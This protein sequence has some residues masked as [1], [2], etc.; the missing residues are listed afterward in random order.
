MI[1]KIFLIFLIGFVNGIAIRQYSDDGC[2]ILS[3]TEY[4]KQNGCYTFVSTGSYL[5]KACNCTMI[6]YNIYNGGNCLG[7]LIGTIITQENFCLG[8]RQKISCNEEPS[9]S[10]NLLNNF[11]LFFLPFF[12]III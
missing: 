8:T 2:N 6:E 7:N 5:F 12:L 11:Y 9:L 1:P 3:R 4:V 10:S